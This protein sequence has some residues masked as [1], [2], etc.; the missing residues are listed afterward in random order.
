M[1]VTI[2]NITIRFLDGKLRALY[3][4][5]VE[6]YD[7]ISGLYRTVDLE[8]SNRL[9]RALSK[10]Y[11]RMGRI[12]DGKLSELDEIEEPAFQEVKKLVEADIRR[13]F[14]YVTGK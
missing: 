14:V 7:G 2:Q 13:R 10:R 9:L 5:W 1:I 6:D 8:A 11:K 12:F 4:G 3:T